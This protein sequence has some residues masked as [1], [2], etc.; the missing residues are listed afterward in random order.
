M[1]IESISRLLNSFG[2]STSATQTQA[3]TSTSSSDEAVKIASGFGKT[4]STE[5]GSGSERS[6]R[7]ADIKQ[8]VNAGTYKPSSSDVAAAVARELFA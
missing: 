7:V 6:K 1:K 4:S 5:Q 8:Q 3:P 2:S